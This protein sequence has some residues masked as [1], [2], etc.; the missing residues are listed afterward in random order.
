MNISQLFEQL[1]ANQSLSETQMQHM[2]Q[3]C[4]S[5]HLNDVQI[6]TFLALM[7]M[8]GESVHE[9]TTA[10]KAMHSFAKHIDLGEKLIDIVGTGGDGKNTFNIS[11]A[12]SFV[13]AASNIKVA[14]HGN[15]SVSSQSGSTDLLEMAGF[16]LNLKDE[17]LQRCI[18]ECSLAFLF[19]PY[20]HPAMQYARNARQQLKIRTLFNLLGPLLNP[21]QVKRQVVGVYSQQWMQPLADVLVNLGSER[22]LMVNSM[23]HLD[24]IS[25]ADDTRILEYQNGEV[26][27]WLLSPQK[28]GM[29]H[30]HLDDIV[31][32]SPSESLNLIL[33]VFNG[34][35]NAARDIVLLNAAAA[36]YC[37]EDQFSFHDAL[38]Q[39]KAAIDSGKALAHFK[40]L[41]LLTVQLA[42]EHETK[43]P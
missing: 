7:R 14:K 41:Q 6:A 29:I 27:E 1:I 13:A 18:E 30:Q 8:K 15:R 10:A 35:H 26:Q 37:A 11:T 17:A 34:E 36:I 42:D 22:L 3:S 39:A 24:E 38:E 9:L 20:F 40:Q 16:Q 21:A 5:G 12:A 43:H 23:D 33:S 4:M 25:I 32:N 19:A 31:V 2:I 28:Y